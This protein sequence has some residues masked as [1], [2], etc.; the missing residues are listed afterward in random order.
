[1]PDLWLC[2]VKDANLMVNYRREEL[3]EEA[4]NS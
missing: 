3:E 2:I 4:K 1:V